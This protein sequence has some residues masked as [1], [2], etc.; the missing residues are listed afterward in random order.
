MSSRSPAMLYTLINDIPVVRHQWSNAVKHCVA[1][2][3]IKWIECNC[4]N[5]AGQHIDISNVQLSRGWWPIPLNFTLCVAHLQHVW[6]MLISWCSLVDAHYV[7]CHC[8]R[9]WKFAWNFRPLPLDDDN[10]CKTM[11]ISVLPDSV[12]V[13]KLHR[14]CVKK[15]ACWAVGAIAISQSFTIFISVTPVLCFVNITYLK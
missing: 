10:L 11:S 3:S 14:T 15:Y 13:C 7:K 1:V 6:L 4:T 5:N 2:N 8:H 9:W 12:Y